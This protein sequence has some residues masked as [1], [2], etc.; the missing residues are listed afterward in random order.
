[1]VAIIWADHASQADDSPL[2]AWGIGANVGYHLLFLAST[3][4]W[5]MSI[6]PIP[7]YAMMLRE[8]VT[9]RPWRY[10]RWRWARKRVK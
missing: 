10:R 8:K 9:S 1:L 7:C 6:E 2:V 5:V 3:F 4:D